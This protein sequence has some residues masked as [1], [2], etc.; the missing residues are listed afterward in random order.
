M[1]LRS[2][3]HTKPETAADG[4][5]T[6]CYVLGGG[7]LGIAIARRLCEAD[8]AVT[9]VGADTDIDDIRSLQGNP[10]TVDVLRDAGVTGAATVVVATPNDGRNLLVA[11]LVKT[12]F[13]V[14]DVFVVVHAPDRSDL[15]AA[16]G[17]EPICA[18]SVLA[19][20]VV[21]DVTPRLTEV[22]VA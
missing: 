15:V 4:S 8:R 5:D 16:A 14:A 10:S 18:T 11:Q 12:R 22:D 13:D 9:L 6:D 19:D 2:I 3:A 21:T 17:H 1:K 7:A 20:A